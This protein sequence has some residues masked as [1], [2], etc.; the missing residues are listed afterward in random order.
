MAVQRSL[1][2]GCCCGSACSL[3]LE[4]DAAPAEKVPAPPS[5]RKPAAADGTKARAAVAAAADAQVRLSTI[6]AFSSIT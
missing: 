3:K 1:A 5:A 6:K 4:E 2:E